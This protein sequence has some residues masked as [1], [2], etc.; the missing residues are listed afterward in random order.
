MRSKFYLL[1][2]FPFFVSHSFSQTIK[3][4]EK[5]DKIEKM[6]R[7]GYVV[8]IQLE[9]P[10]VDKAWSKKTKEYGKVE[11]K[12][13]EY[14]VHEAMMPSFSSSPVKF[15][16]K[17]TEK[18]KQGT[19]VWMAVDLG[20]DFVTKKHVKSEEVEKFLYQFAVETYQ[21]DINIQIQEA[22][23]TLLKTSK[24]YERT[25]AGELKVRNKMQK[26]KEQKAALLEELKQTKSDSIQLVKDL[27]MNKLEQKQDS[28]EVVKLK[29]AVEAVKA[30]LTAIK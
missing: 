14:I 30:K 2:L 7:K 20:T 28:L 22:E 15:Y 29:K 18:S 3:V 25:V 24:E 17:V 4:L 10:F 8:L 19:E 5:E 23:K 26:N 11:S 16:S 1:V 6:Q 21:A 13:N 12:G 9:E 27:E